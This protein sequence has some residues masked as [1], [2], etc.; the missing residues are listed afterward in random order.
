MCS[1]ACN[2]AIS[3]SQ[4]HNRPLRLLLAQSLGS[5]RSGVQTVEVVLSDDAV[6]GPE[7]LAKIA[8]SLRAGTVMPGHEG[9]AGECRESPLKVPLCQWQVRML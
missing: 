3:A 7:E 4:P 1:F 9:S 5:C 8:G 6:I 2:S